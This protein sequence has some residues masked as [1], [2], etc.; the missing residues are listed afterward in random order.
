[1]GGVDPVNQWISAKFCPL[2]MLDLDSGSSRLFVSKWGKSNWN[3]KSR[4]DITKHILFASHSD[5]LT[6]L[7]RL[8]NLSNVTFGLPELMIV[9]RIAVS[10]YVATPINY[11]VESRWRPE[12]NFLGLVPDN[13]RPSRFFLTSTTRLPL[14]IEGW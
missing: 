5:Q 14:S 7:S 11:I 10:E 4:I 3:R 1:M 9:L 2:D 12:F 8:S 13:S 6:T